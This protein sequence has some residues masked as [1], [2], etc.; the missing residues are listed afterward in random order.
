MH[1]H[2]EKEHQF[3]EFLTKKYPDLCADTLPENGPQA[4]W[5]DGTQPEIRLRLKE[6]K[7]PQSRRQFRIPEAQREH[8]TKTINELLQYKL[9]QPSLSPYSNPVFLVPK[10]P[11]KDGSPGGWRFVWDGRSVNKAIES[12]AYL[13]PRVEDLIDRI[14]RVKHEAARKG[15]T[16]MW[17]STIDLRTSFWQLKLHE[18]SR[19]L[20]AFS[21]SAGTF[22]WT[23]LPMGLLVSSAHL[24]RW[25]EAV[26]RPFS[27]TTFEYV[28]EKKG[29][30][31][32][33]LRR[34]FGCATPY[35]DDTAVISF[36]LR[37]GHER[38]LT[39]V[40]DALNRADALIQPGNVSFFVL[41]LTFWV[42]LCL[43][44]EFR[45][46]TQSRGNKQLASF[47]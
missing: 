37:D 32:G 11:K 44:Q 47:D 3:R 10:P 43:R 35:I 4:K 39:M 15:I 42:T 20:M 1:A 9:I 17:I 16:E 26:L 27:G 33:H 25:I 36:G 31:S 23:V 7:F 12:D 38:L 29:A 6:G 28:E 45:S 40:L 5:P 13:I 14:A 21:T 2:A 18:D 22:E 41:A 24:Q 34:G 8:L 19:P 30:P 46:R